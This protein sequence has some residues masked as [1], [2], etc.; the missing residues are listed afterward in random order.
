M[1]QSA[2][3]QALTVKIG[4]IVVI[5]SPVDQAPSSLDWQRWVRN[6]ALRFERFESRSPGRVVLLD[7]L[8]QQSDMQ[9]SF[10]TEIFRQDLLAADP[11]AI[12]SERTG[13]HLLLMR[14]GVQFAA[15]AWV[16]SLRHL[17]QA[18][19]ADVLSKFLDQQF[20]DWRELASDVRDDSLFVLSDL[21]NKFVNASEHCQGWV[22]R[23]VRSRLVNEN[24]KGSWAA[25]VM[26]V[27]DDLDQE[28]MKLRLQRLAVLSS[29]DWCGDPEWQH[30][31]QGALDTV[32]SQ[33][34]ELWVSVPYAGLALDIADRLKIVGLPASTRL[35]SPS[36]VLGWHPMRD[37]LLFL[38][39]PAKR[40]LLVLVDSLE[41]VQIFYVDL[42]HEGFSV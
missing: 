12:L 42:V 31:I 11:M 3:L 37:F 40:R 18:K 28:G 30:S 20:S 36:A 1:P 29:I 34:D 27:Y 21:G 2:E 15:S 17:T 10:E 23:I 35:R 16:E 32:V 41:R 38:K 7:H 4:R 25:G 33:T 22:Q 13:G 9:K 5:S 14:G 19:Y 39:S 26:R 6:T 8:D 24:K